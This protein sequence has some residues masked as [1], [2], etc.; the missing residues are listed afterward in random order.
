[1]NIIK[2]KELLNMWDELLITGESAS[3]KKALG[4]NGGIE[5][6]IRRTVGEPII[7]DFESYKNQI[8]IQDELCKELPKWADVIRSKPEIMDGFSWTRKDFIELYFEH[9]RLVI[10]KIRRITDRTSTV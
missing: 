1:M 6:R 7:F 3:R 5:G 10:E 9:F 4:G 8:T 2:V